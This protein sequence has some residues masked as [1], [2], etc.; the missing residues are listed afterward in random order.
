MWISKM[1]KEKINKLI[2]KWK[3]VEKRIEKHSKKIIKN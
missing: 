1:N 3:M 2:E